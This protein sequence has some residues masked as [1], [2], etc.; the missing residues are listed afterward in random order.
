[1]TKQHG[2]SKRTP[3]TASSA[4]SGAASGRGAPAHSVHRGA[5]LALQRA[6]RNV[7]RARASVDGARIARQTAAVALRE[8]GATYQQIGDV[9]GVSWIHARRIVLGEA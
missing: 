8:K 5:V 2:P 4:S 6:D 3:A 9:L 7:D 1:M